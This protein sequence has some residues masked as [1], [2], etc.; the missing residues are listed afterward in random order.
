MTPATSAHPEAPHA[1]DWARL[2]RAHNPGPMTLDGTNTWVLRAPGSPT[3]ILV[4]P[5][6]G[7]PDHLAAITAEEGIA[8]IVTTHWHPDHTDAAAALGAELD[9]PVR[10]WDPKWCANGG[11]PLRDGETLNEAGLPLI[12]RHTPGHTGDSVCLVGADAVLTGDT[13]LGRGTT[14]VLWPDGDL[15]SYFASLD[16]LEALGDRSVLPGHGPTLPSLA[17]ICGAYR[18]H[19]EQRLNQVRAALDAGAKEPIDVVRTVY[20]EVDRSVWPAAEATVRAQ[21][22]YLRRGQDHRDREHNDPGK[23]LGGP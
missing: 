19:R 3:A 23:E 22:E 13:V 20:A 21:L 15:T 6:P 12:V 16:L 5:G 10:A 9:V 4:D 7:L 1:P 11:E 14:V 18:T 2:L 8:L 17:Q